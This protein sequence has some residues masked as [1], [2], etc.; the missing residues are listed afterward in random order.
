MKREKTQ[1]ERQLHQGEAR[2]TTGT[3]E[4]PKCL[5]GLPEE[6]GTISF[7]NELHYNDVQVGTSIVFLR[8]LGELGREGWTSA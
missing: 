2:R 7:P 4:L 3:H 5:L 1:Y 8:F 6:G